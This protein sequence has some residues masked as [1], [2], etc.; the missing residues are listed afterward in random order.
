M[1]LSELPIPSLLE[2]TKQRKQFEQDAILLNN[3]IKLLQI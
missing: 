2:A 3:R 1:S